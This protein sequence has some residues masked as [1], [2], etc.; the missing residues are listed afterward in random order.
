MFTA[1]HRV[2]RPAP[3]VG[4]PHPRVVHVGRH[5]PELRSQLEHMP[6]AAAEHAH[7]GGVVVTRNGAIFVRQQP[8]EHRFS[9]PLGPTIAVCSPAGW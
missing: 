7:P 8:E 6:V 4:H 2:E 3:E 1:R 5:D 9:R